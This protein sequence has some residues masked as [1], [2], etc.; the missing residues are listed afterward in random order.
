MECTGRCVAVSEPDSTTFVATICLKL[1]DSSTA[2]QLAR[3]VI[4]WECRP[5]PTIQPLP[6][7]YFLKLGFQ[8]IAFLPMLK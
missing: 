8:S 6:L 1:G 7:G 2:R 4:R 3:D 5:Y